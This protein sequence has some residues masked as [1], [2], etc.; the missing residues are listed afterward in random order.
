MSLLS[1]PPVMSA[2]LGAERSRRE[3]EKSDGQSDEAET[4]Q[5]A[6]KREVESD[7]GSTVFVSTP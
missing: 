5:V 7:G 3:M 1:D 4:V 2:S 6:G